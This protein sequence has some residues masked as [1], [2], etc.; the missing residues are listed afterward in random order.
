MTLDQILDEAESLPEDELYMF[1]EILSNRIKDMKRK[2]LVDT[3]YQSRREYD[4]GMAQ[5]ASVDN[6]MNEIFA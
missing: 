1:N 2:D 4:A 6:I 3:V 5:E